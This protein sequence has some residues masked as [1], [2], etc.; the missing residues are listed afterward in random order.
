MKTSAQ[1]M[2]NELNIDFE[3]N[4]LHDA[5]YDVKMTNEI[6]KKLIWNVEV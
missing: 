4:K 6:F 3:A 2:L 5:M 1:A